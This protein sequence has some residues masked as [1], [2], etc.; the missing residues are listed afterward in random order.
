MK[1]ANVFSR[2]DVL[3]AND[4][5]QGSSVQVKDSKS[6]FSRNDTK[7]SY[8]QAKLSSEEINRAFA[9]ALR[10]MSTYGG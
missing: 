9:D 1:T 3:R 4:A 2:E 5:M 10:S 7:Q 8:V 6:V